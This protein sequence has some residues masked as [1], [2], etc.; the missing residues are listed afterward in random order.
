MYILQMPNVRG[1]C[2]TCSKPA[3]FSISMNLS[4]AGKR[5]TDVRRYSYAPLSPE[6][7]PPTIGRI[8]W[9]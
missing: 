4:G 2:S 3:D 7:N 9:K 5:R 6:I 1:L 8:F